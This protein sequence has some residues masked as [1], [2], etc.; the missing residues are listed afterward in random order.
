[1]SPRPA[2]PVPA[3]LC[4]NWP[5]IPSLDADA[6]IARQL[7]LRL[8]AAMK[9]ASLRETARATGVDRATIGT[10]LNGGSWPDIITLAKL[11]REF[12]PLWPGTGS[13]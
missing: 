10:I 13:R 5:N 4:D 1:M 8:R 2:R 12:G 9:G 3:E 6:E 11:E 7:A